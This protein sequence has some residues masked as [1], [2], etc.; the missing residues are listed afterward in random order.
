MSTPQDPL[1]LAPLHPLCED[2]SSYTSESPLGYK[3]LCEDLN[4]FCPLCTC[5]GC[6]ALITRYPEYPIGM[7][8]GSA[9]WS[10]FEDGTQFLCQKQPVSDFMFAELLAL[11]CSILASY[12]KPWRMITLPEVPRDTILELRVD[13]RSITHTKSR[14]TDKVMGQVWQ[15]C[16]VLLRWEVSSI[17]ILEAGMMGVLLLDSILQHKRASRNQ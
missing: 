9:E 1:V 12:T 3:L 7:W 5:E 11:I 8:F 16:R 6:S 13:G 15:N 10:Q 4:L 14:T 17:W 2:K